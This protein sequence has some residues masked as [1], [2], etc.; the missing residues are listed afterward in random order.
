M[1][2]KWKMRRCE[3]AFSIG[4]LLETFLAAH[5]KGRAEDLTQLWQHWPIVMGAEIAALAH[6]L[7]TRGDIL[8]I[9][10]EDNAAMQE[11]AFMT[12]E[13]LERA[14]AFLERSRL[15]AVHLSL[16]QGRKGLNRE[17]AP[18]PENLTGSEQP[19]RAANPAP[20]PLGQLELD[21]ASPV[22]RVYWKYVKR[23]G[24]RQPESSRQ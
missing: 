14:N 3:G 12:E 10:A 4:E 5:P 20:G 23:F 1:K 22:G 11:L 13:I 19:F 21:P 8:L 24:K 16:L 9:G 18:V 15:T 17:I 2:Y 7:G 6:P